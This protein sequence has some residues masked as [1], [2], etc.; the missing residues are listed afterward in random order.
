MPVLSKESKK[1]TMI[2]GP[3]KTTMNLGTAKSA[4][5]LFEN[6]ISVNKK[7][8][9]MIKKQSTLPYVQQKVQLPVE[10]LK[11]QVKETKT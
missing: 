4:S 11:Q 1:K 7:Q 10:E 3:S 9:F 8:P 2:F 5:P 6:S